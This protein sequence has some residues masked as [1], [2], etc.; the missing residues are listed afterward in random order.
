MV[1][2]DQ[3]KRGDILAD[4]EY[5]DR[6]YL[7]IILAVYAPDKLGDMYKFKVGQVRFDHYNE[8]QIPVF[9]Q[10]RTPYRTYTE[11][12]DIWTNHIQNK[13][14]KF[15]EDDYKLDKMGG[16]RKRTVKRYRKKNNTKKQRKIRKI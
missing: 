2:V 9:I 7:D 4:K 1:Y 5:W 8:K 10:L 15:K 6:E 3:I 14:I 16:K 11:N 13:I 12:D